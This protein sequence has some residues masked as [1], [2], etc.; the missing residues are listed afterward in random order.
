MPSLSSLL[1][2]LPRRFKAVKR[3]LVLSSSLVLL[4]ITVLMMTNLVGLKVSSD[5]VS[6]E[7]RTSVIEALAVQLSVLAEKGKLK[8]A[9]ATISRLVL[10]ND[11]VQAA[12][13]VRNTGV[14]LAQVGNTELLISDR[15]LEGETQLNVPIYSSGEVW[16]EVRMVFE[17]SNN[18]WA[19]VVAIAIFALSLLLAFTAFLFR[20]LVQLDPRKAVPGRVDSAMDLFRAGV[21]VLDRNLR[22]VMVNESAEKLVARSKDE[23]LGYK[24]DDWP[25]KQSEHIDFPWNSTFDS[26][27]SVSDCPMSLVAGGGED[28]SLLVSCVF[29]GEP[30]GEYKGVLVTL[31]DI[32]TVEKQNRELTRMV[33]RLRETQELIKE[34]NS[35]LKKLATI[36]PLSGIANRR[37]L[38]EEL[39]EQVSVAIRDNS[40]LS[41]I[42]TDIDFFKNVNDTYGHQVGDEVISACAGV[43]QSL[44]GDEYFVGRYGGEEF[45]VVLPGLNA[46]EAAQFAERARISVIALAYGDQLAVDKLSASYG[47]A[48][49]SAGATD[50]SSLVDAADKALYKAKENGRNCVVIFDPEAESGEAIADVSP[51]TS[52]TLI[53]KAES[54]HIKARVVELESMLAIRDREISR[55][56]DYDALTGIPLR[57]VFLQRAE[58]ELSRAARY[59]TLV[60]VLSFEIRDIDEFLATFGY[61]RAEALIKE[62]VERLQS[63]LRSTDVISMLSSEHSLSRITSNEYAILLSSLREATSAM[64]VVTRMKR[65][66]SEPFSVAGEKVYVGVS[67]GIAMSEHQS[68]NADRLLSDANKAR[69]VAAMRSEKFSHVYATP[70]L[71]EQSNDYIRLEADLHEAIENNAIETWY[72]PKLDLSSNRIV[73]MEALLR[74]RHPTRGF[75]SPELFV[76]VAEA[77]GLIDVLSIGVL[78]STLEQIVVWRSMGFTDLKVSIN[79]SPLQLRSESLARDTLHE[80]HKAGVSGSQLEIEITETSFLENIEQARKDLLL[81]KDG[82]ISVSLDDF[83]TG[84]TSLSLLSQ[85]PLDVVKIDRS[86][87]DAIAE[88]DRSRDVVGSVISMAHALDLLVVGEGVETSAQLKVLSELSCDQIQGYLISKPKPADEITKFLLGQSQREVRNVA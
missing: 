36:D 39:H 70:G 71:S 59:E 80:L 58:F 38:M 42:M 88:S 17:P 83:G 10:R 53:Q 27:L 50:G 37:A 31:D 73:G 12:S 56:G 7:S 78:R 66:L 16:G 54:D 48:D 74:W 5:H 26:E 69:G 3:P 81:L 45:V 51:S 14:V 15:Y 22:I 75:V 24:L 65:L 60:G 46:E 63:G 86:F 8:E 40:D 85:L 61:L 25:W 1:N 9:Q 79:V 30:D 32:T 11:D 64:I 76:S 49:M 35:E 19:Q 20:A 67:I 84:Y 4:A 57:A 13:L 6:R 2:R 55:L 62:V 33:L 47:V 52:E 43:L 28:L 87:I 41:C 77:N 18:R 44:C 72:Q 21:I 68:D 34:K 82:G 29:V 23:L